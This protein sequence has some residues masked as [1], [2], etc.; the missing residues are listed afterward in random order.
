MCAVSDIQTRRVL[1][2]Q[3]QRLHKTRR[4]IHSSTPHGFRTC[5]VSVNRHH[6]A[7][8]LAYRS[9]TSTPTRSSAVSSARK[10]YASLSR[11]LARTRPSTSSQI[12][13]SAPAHSRTS[14]TR[15]HLVK[16]QPGWAPAH[17]RAGLSMRALT[18]DEVHNK[19]TGVGNG[20]ER[21]W[22]VDAS[23]RYK[24][25]TS[26]FMGSVMSGGESGNTA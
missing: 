14:R 18:P 23:P 4:W 12:S 25:I 21:W 13:S 19:G 26:Q 5:Q 20:K 1:G 24:G 2:C 16:P 22:T 9:S 8:S 17:Y 15:S 10:S 7:P 6:S 11:T 3:R